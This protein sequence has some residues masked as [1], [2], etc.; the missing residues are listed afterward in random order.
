MTKSQAT[1]E[2]FVGAASSPTDPG[3]VNQRLSTDEE[4]ARGILRD[5]NA[6]DMDKEIAFNMQDEGL[7]PRRGE[8]TRRGRA[9]A[10]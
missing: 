2:V 9:A 10:D 6:I 8:A 3:Q 1:T 5:E 7:Q 4:I